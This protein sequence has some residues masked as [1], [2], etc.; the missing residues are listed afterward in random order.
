MYAIR[1]NP[2]RALLVQAD[3]IVNQRAASNPFVTPHVVDEMVAKLEAEYARQD[4]TRLLR[5]ISVA[6][7]RLG[8]L[9]TEEAA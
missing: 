1:I 9:Q 4:D 6:L 7:D 2:I 5:R 3:R 8:D